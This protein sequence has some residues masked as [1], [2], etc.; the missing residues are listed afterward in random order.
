MPLPSGASRH[1]CI[2]A[3]SLLISLTGCMAE[4]SFPVRSDGVVRLSAD[5]GGSG[6][7]PREWLAVAQTQLAPLLPADDP[8]PLL[9]DDLATTSGNARD[10]YRHFGVR[11]DR[12]HTLIWNLEGIQ[13]TAQVA[14]QKKIDVPPA[15]DEFNDVWI[16]VSDKVQLSGRLGLARDAAGAR[17]ADCIVV[18]PGILG[19]KSIMRTRDICFALREAGHHV[20]ALDLRGLGQTRVRH[21]EIYSTFGALETGELL[22]VSTWLEAKSYVRDTGLIGF[23]WGANQ[24]L[25][26]AWEDGR[27]DDDPC[28]G[29]AIRPFLRPRDGRRHFAAGMIAY[30]PVMRFEEIVATSARP[31]AI[32]INPVL[33]GLQK[34]VIEHMQERGYPDPVGC[35][36]DLFRAE[37]LRSEFAEFDRVEEDGL[38]YV[39]LMPYQGKT[40]CDKLEA[41]RMPVLMVHAVND[42]L[43]AAQDVA[44]FVAQVDNPN[45]A[46]MILAGGGHDGFAPYA[47]DHFYSLM[48]NFF[49]KSYGAAASLERLR[50][51]TSKLAAAGR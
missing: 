44:D 35:L 22:A 10:V 46:A 27:R 30:S 18:L 47:G 45:V 41:A 49:D 37:I 7:P 48:L 2:F 39:R 21:P 28:V 19:D 50:H 13:H 26:A 25:L 4:R 11:G 9:T 51:D 15:W 3:A 16:P 33:N 38:R 42:P 6:M 5:G 12:M 31:T 23:C 34:R 17:F 8:A 20:L 1:C 40:A 24:A 43:A 29:D 14:Q 32:W 36:R